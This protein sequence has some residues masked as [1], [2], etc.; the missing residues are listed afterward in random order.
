[1]GEESKFWY[2][3]ALNGALRFCASVSVSE[4]FPFSLLSSEMSMFRQRSNERRQNPGGRAPPPPRL[5]KAQRDDG[6]AGGTVCRPGPGEE[7]LLQGRVGPLAGL[8]APLFSVCACVW[9]V[10][11]MWAVLQTVARNG[12]FESRGLW[13]GKGQDV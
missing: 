12:A 3:V 6:I 13:K 7:G 11:T 5:A 10:E 4:P 2:F 9:P 1:M 8:F